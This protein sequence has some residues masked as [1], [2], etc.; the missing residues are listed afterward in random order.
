MRWS[1]ISSAYT[2]LSGDLVALLSTTLSLCLHVTTSIACHQI[3][4]SKVWLNIEK[5]S[6]NQLSKSGHFYFW[7]LVNMNWIFS[8]MNGLF[9]KNIK[10]YIEKKNRD[11]QWPKLR[12]TRAF[13]LK[14]AEGFPLNTITK[15]TRIAKRNIVE[16]RQVVVD[17]YF[18]R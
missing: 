9:Q 3:S 16:S 1:K 6:V 13:T 14:R 7:E 8:E 18:L 17:N 15:K 4:T 11:E 5:L 12:H 10:V 2:N